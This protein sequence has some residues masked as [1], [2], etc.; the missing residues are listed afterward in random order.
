MVSIW[1]VLGAF[2]VGGYA[3]AI[4]VG[5]MTVSHDDERPRT[6]MPLEPLDDAAARLSF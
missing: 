3:G 6:D 5:I 1:W 4:L 2:V